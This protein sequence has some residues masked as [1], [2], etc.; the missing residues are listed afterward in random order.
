MLKSK[1]FIREGVILSVEGAPQ[2]GTLKIRA[3]PFDIDEDALNSTSFT[4]WGKNDPF[5]FVSFLPIYF[6]QA[7]KV[8]ERVLLIYSNPD[9]T[10][11]NDQYWISSSPSNILNINKETYLQT[12][13]NTNLGDNIADA[14]SLV[15]P[16]SNV[17]GNVLESGNPKL[18]N[19]KIDGV[20]P[21][22]NEVA[23]MGRGS[24]DIIIGEESLLLRAGKVLEFIPNTIPT[25]NPNRA[26]IDLSRFKEKTQ[27]VGD[28]YTYFYVQEDSIPV[29]KYV[30]YDID[31]LESESN[32]SGTI[33]IYDL[34]EGINTLSNNLSEDTDLTDYL[35][36]SP[37]FVYTFN[38]LPKL[39]AVTV[40]NTFIGKCFND[41]GLVNML[42]EYN[43]Q[44]SEPRFPGF[45]CYGPKISQGIRSTDVII[46]TNSD[47]FRNNVTYFTKKGS[48]KV[49]S[50]NNV[51]SIPKPKV[52]KVQNK[53]T[54]KVD[55]TYVTIGGDTLYLISHNT[56]VPSRG[57]IN[58]NNSI[59]TLTQKELDLIGTKT[60]PMVRGDELM[61]LI[62][63]IVDFLISHVHNPNE[64]PDNGPY[65]DKNVTTNMILQSLGNAKDTILNQY[66]R[67]N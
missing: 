63:L 8:D 43:Y 10:N 5:V 26:F 35:G 29:K 6:N 44:L 49:Y 54:T 3:R 20:F 18:I 21:K 59:T 17:I 40:I 34:K 24:A 50:P 12:L 7:P 36:N 62:G 25:K 45:F 33:K 41:L 16:K 65:G 53:V 51:V 32:Y 38:A 23:L 67:I 19:P 30:V 1:R 60:D 46:S 14:K 9:N 27:D 37:L 2:P 55:D 28:P 4:E 31:N 11:F 15:G 22:T 61:K 13:S 47:Y 48:S 39:S 52:E 42:P 56:I 64:A 66:I 57:P 58:L